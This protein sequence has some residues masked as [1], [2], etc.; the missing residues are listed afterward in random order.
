MAV[1]PEIAARIDA[2]IRGV[3]KLAEIYTA[4]IRDHDDRA[5]ILLAAAIQSVYCIAMDLEAGGAVDE[6]NSAAAALK[7]LL[8]GF[9]KMEPSIVRMETRPAEQA[10]VPKELIH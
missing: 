2:V 9:S 1:S 4:G 6:K 10:P 7:L 3:I 8:D 5:S